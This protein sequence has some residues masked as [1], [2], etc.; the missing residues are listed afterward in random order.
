MVISTMVQASVMVVWYRPLIYR[1]GRRPE[2]PR[3]HQESPS[4]A[5]SDLEGVGLGSISPS[6]LPP[7]SVQSQSPLLSPGWVLVGEWR[8]GGGCVER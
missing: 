7:Q 5:L 8:G 6:P 2:R 1:G 4:K 3:T